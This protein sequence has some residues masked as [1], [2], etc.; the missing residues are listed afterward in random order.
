MKTG[1]YIQREDKEDL[2]LSPFMNPQEAPKWEM[3]EKVQWISSGMVEANQIKELD[4]IAYLQIEKGVNLES[5]EEKYYSRLFM[6]AGVFIVVYFVMSFA[7]RDPIPIL[8]E[9]GLA[10]IATWGTWRYLKK[11]N[12]QGEMSLKKK[13][14]L[15]SRIS[16][17]SSEISPFVGT[18]ENY[19]D[20]LRS[21]NSLTLSDMIIKCHGRDLEPLGEIPD[22]QFTDMVDYTLKVK[23]PKLYYKKDQIK[24]ARRDA[25]EN[26]R[27]SAYLVNLGQNKN[28]DLALLALSIICEE[29]IINN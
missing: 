23:F 16:E 8:D 21:V 18:V 11:R 9:L 1:Y 25:D 4:N 7:I 19:L 3:L 6:S 20:N 22:R 10:S 24:E 5:Q 15:K 2:I 27:L 26:V 14:E 13:L 29:T 28:Q 17:A 12:N